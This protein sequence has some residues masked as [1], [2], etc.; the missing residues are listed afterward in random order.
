[1]CTARAARAGA[2]KLFTR[3]VLQ[4]VAAHCERPIIFPMSN[5]TSR[6]VRPALL[7]LHCMPA[8]PT[9]IHT[10]LWVLFFFGIQCRPLWVLPFSMNVEP[11]L[12]ATP[13][14]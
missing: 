3:E 7:P 6:M 14:L 2:G 5:P 8:G 1:V 4:E 10:T 9:H 11:A 12:T 13:H